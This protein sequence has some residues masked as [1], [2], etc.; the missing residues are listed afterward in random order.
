LSSQQAIFDGKDGI[1]IQGTVT[2]LPGIVFAL[3]AAVTTSPPSLDEL[4]LHDQAIRKENVEMHLVARIRICT[5][6]IFLLA[7]GCAEPCRM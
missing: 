5:F 3:P 1:K 2:E 7:P 4:L 6:P